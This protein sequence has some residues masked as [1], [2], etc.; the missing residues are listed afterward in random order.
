VTDSPPPL[1][2]S[3]QDQHVPVFGTWPRIYGAVVIL[4]VVVIAL[5]WV[6]SRWP[7]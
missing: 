3:E 5:I 2:P 4:N 6:F 1:D 7:W